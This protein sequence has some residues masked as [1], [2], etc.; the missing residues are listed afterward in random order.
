MFSILVFGMIACF[1]SSELNIDEN[2]VLVLT[3]D[4]FK[5]GLASADYVL[6]EFYAPWCGHC[7]ALAP[8]YATAAKTL[9]DEHPD[10]SV[11]L[12]MVDATAETD[13]GKEYG[14][15]GYPT[16]KFFYK[17]GE[18]KEYGGGRKAPEI[19]SWL[20][21]KT[22]PPAVDLKS[23]EEAKSFSTAEDIAV[24]GF[25]SDQTTEISKQFIETAKS[26]DDIKFAIIT[27][28][29]VAK[30]LEISDGQ[31][32]LFRKFDEPRLVF[33]GD[34]KQAEISSFVKSNQLPLIV[35]FSDQT[36]P[37]IFGGDVKTH[38]LF[39]VKKAEA[40]S[41]LAEF[42][43]AAKQL[44][45]RAV[46]VYLDIEESNNGR[47]MEFFNLKKEDG[48]QLRVVKMGDEMD[49]FQP[50]FTEFTEANFV[51]FLNDVLDGKAKKHMMTEEVADDWDKEPVKVLVGKNFEEVAF[52]KTKDVLVE[53][54]A[55]WCGHCKALAPIYE[56]LGAAYKDNANVV[57]A[58]MD[59]TK[60][61][62][63]AVKVQGFPT[64]ALIRRDDNKVIMFEGGRTFDELKAFVDSKGE[65]TS[66]DA[67][68]DEATEEEEK[69]RIDDEL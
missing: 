59:S 46:F 20:L 39:F 56:E 45:G 23:A 28:A 57:I 34:A 38:A 3:T 66:A 33:S 21:K 51:Q 7:K 10:V 62:I 60:N 9:R 58:K 61:E 8:E 65:K 25:F 24:V 54:Y 22:G 67:E 18:P 35:E 48:T 17:A 63:S 40:D 30:E 15:R 6:V 4:T 29:S 52:D 55:P 53:F 44:K 36:A 68:D 12:A 32:V 64:I 37:K 47:V 19:V 14:V 13:L 1:V 16:L 27:D 49:K 42:R 31:I 50:D 43:N 41:L 26:F 5:E 2:G 69:K 11:K